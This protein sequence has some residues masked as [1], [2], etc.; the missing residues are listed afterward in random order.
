MKAVR[1]VVR[2]AIKF[3]GPAHRKDTRLP[4]AVYHPT[5][6]AE[7]KLAA[8]REMLTVYRDVYLVN[9]GLRGEK[10]LEAAHRHYLG[11][12]NKRWAKVPMALL[13]DSDGDKIRPMRNVRRYIQKAEH[14]ML[15][16]AR[17]E[18]PGKY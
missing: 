6:G 3:R 16:V 11:R 5:I 2:S 17:G 10:L 13:P 7:P 9:Q 1:H 8:V 4:S 14:V 12:K 18:F 15:N